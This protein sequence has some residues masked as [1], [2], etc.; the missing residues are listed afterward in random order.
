MDR[1]DAMTV[2][3]A[4]VEEGSL[5]AASRR[6]RAPLATVSRK[7][8][9]LERH[10]RTQLLVRTSRRV[11]LT[12]AGRAY[13]ASARRILEQVEEAEREASGEYSAPRGEL[14]VTAP[15]MFG[16]THVLPVALEFL[17]AQPEIDLR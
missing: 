11:K 5:S 14:H 16:R 2:L 12:D 3:I 15:T 7:V 6:L 13:V 9:D 1:F 8:A 10:L 17:R 4:V